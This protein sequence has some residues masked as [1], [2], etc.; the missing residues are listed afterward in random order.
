MRRVSAIR[1]P[2]LANEEALLMDVDSIAAGLLVGTEQRG[3]VVLPWLV[4]NRQALNDLP[5][6]MD[7]KSF[8]GLSVR[9]LPYS[10]GGEFRTNLSS[11]SPASVGFSSSVSTRR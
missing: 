2:A 5:T 9:Q 3:W 1:S 10:F 4:I 7:N 6:K 8:R 11:S